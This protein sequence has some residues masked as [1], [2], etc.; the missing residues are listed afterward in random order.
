M[1]KM[2]LIPALVL[3]SVAAFAHKPES[4]VK[5]VSKKMDVV[6]FKVSCEMIGASMEVYD[7]TGKVI[8]SEKV[9][10]H[11]VIVDFYAEPSGVYTIHVQKNGKDEAITYTKESVSH[12]ER[13]SASYITVTQS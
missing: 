10:D 9:T 5:V 7:A 4:P 11:K 8:F 13:A 2:M 6:Y 3:M 12:A 1:K